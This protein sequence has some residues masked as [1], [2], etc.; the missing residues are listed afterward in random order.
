MEDRFVA[1]CAEYRLPQPELNVVVNGREVDAFFR[2]EGVIVELDS[3][4]FHSDRQS[5]EADRDK[6][7]EA[8]AEDLL[9][10]RP[11]WRRLTVEAEQEADRLKTILSL[12]RK[13]R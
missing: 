13:A 6:D 9:T 2:A 3:W 5:F 4:R 12:R 10:V 1:L 11:T 8:L 7:A